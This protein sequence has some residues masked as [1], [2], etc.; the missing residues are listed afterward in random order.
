MDS[1]TRDGQATVSSADP[2]DMLRT[3]LLAA[4][5]ALPAKVR[6]AASRAACRRVMELEAWTGAACVLLYAPF[7]QEVDATPLMEAAWVAGKRVLLPRCLRDCPGEMETAPAACL[8]DLAPGMYGIRE[9][10]GHCEAVEDCPDLAV[11]PGVGYDRDLFRLGY[12]GGYYDRFLAAH[13][14]IRT[15]GLAFSVQVLESLPHDPWDKPVNH[16][17]TEEYAWSNPA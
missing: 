9:P 5:K 2:K 1:T 15:V 8:A 14:G 6:R 3:N 12:G 16:L 4:R 11:L 13:P 7:R 10:A 17:V